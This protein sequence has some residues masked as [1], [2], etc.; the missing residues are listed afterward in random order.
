[1]DEK[2]AYELALLGEHLH[3]VGAAF[4]HVHQPVDRDMDAVQRGR[5]LLL[6][7]RRADVS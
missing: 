7:G 6:I 3:S 4:T 2:T 5:E 1:M